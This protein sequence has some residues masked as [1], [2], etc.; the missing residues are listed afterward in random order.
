MIAADHYDNIVALTVFGEFTLEDL[1]EVEQ[2]IED[3]LRFMGAVYLLFDLREMAS[4]TLDVAWEEVQFSRKH[5]Y[6]ID[7]I[8]VVTHN[9]WLSWSAWIAQIFTETDVRVFDEPDDDR[10]WL[11]DGG[12]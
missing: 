2:L 7:R 9:Q 11:T 5:E 10:F 4:F 8:A 3:K 6:E 12:A 1:Q